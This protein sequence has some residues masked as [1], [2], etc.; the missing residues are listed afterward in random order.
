MVKA[1]DEEYKDMITTNVLKSLEGQKSEM[2]FWPICLFL[3][4]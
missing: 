4:G 1:S 2:E 3:F